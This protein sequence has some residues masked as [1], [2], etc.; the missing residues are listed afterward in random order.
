MAVYWVILLSMV[1]CAFLLDKV[2]YFVGTGVFALLLFRLD[3]FNFDTL[4]TVPWLCSCFVCYY[5]NVVGF[6][7]LLLVLCCVVE[8]ELSIF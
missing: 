4:W 8:K 5:R 1:T 7:V 3:C 6:L 2:G